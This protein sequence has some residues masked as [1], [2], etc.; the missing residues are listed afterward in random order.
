MQQKKDCK[1]FSGYKPCQAGKLCE[2]CNEY[3][4]MGKRILLINLDALG[5]VLRTTAI[6]KPIKRKYKNSFIIWLTDESALALLENNPL[7]DGVYPYSF[8]NILPLFCEKFDVLLNVDKSRKSASVA[9]L[10]KAKEKYGFGISETGVICPLNKEAEYLYNLGL[11]DEEKFKKNNKSE[12]ELLGSALGL[13]YKRDEYILGLTEQEKAFTHQYRQ[14]VGFRKRDSVIGFNTG[15]SNLYAYKKLSFDKQTELIDKLSNSINGARIALLGGKEDTEN[16]LKLKNHFKDRI[17]STPTGMGLRKGILFI[18]ACD[19]I[20]T[21]DTLALHI[22]IALKKSIAAW[23]SISCENE[24]D[25]YER[26]IKI[27]ADVDCR[28]CWKKACSKTPL[29]NEMVN[30]EEICRAVKELLKNKEEVS[31]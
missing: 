21:G 10:I 31:V 7:I 24:I 28:P 1:K 8:E 9:N 14:S 2:D 13:Q 5:D 25:L 15:C 19:I 30:I 18:N 26:G 3:A 12:Q 16:N 27:T 22:A 4:P 29:C 6:L 11:D 17:I 23:F 20:I